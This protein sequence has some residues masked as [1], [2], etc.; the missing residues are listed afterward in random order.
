MSD[1]FFTLLAGFGI[2]AVIAGDAVGLL[3][4]LDVFSPAQGLIACF[5]VET[6]AHDVFLP[7]KRMHRHSLVFHISKKTAQEGG[8]E[9]R[10]VKQR[11]SREKG[12]R[13]FLDIQL[14]S[15]TN[16]RDRNGSK[17]THLLKR[18]KVLKDTFY[19]T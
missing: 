14:Q 17:R 2:Q 9:G 8:G 16:R 1:D 12:G 11:E 4:H 18:Y 3:L 5:A 6:V 19:T 7:S 13:Q 15:K 10:L